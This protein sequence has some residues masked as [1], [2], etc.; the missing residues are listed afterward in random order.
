MKK[1]LYFVSTNFQPNL[2]KNFKK[3]ENNVYILK[4]TNLKYRKRLLYDWGWGQELGFEI[5]P[6]PT[7]EELIVIVSNFDLT[8]R[9]NK[10]KM[11]FFGAISVIMQDYIEELIAFLAEKLQTDF[12]ENTQ[13]KNNF[14]Y[15]SFSSEETRNKGR[16]PGGVGNRSYEDVFK[17]YSQWLEISDKVIGSI[18]N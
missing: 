4:H 16:I 2:E 5:I 17:Q 13:T 12:F 15:F 8:I 1:Q 3:I 18:Y 10:L 9:S 14:S 11:N 7:F 6:K